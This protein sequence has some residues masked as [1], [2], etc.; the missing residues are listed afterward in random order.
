M[1]GQR[2]ACVES[3]AVR[4][5]RSPSLRVAAWIVGSREAEARAASDDVTVSF[6]FADDPTVV[7]AGAVPESAAAA[8]AS[9]SRLIAD[10]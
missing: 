2:V 4:V 8:A 3:G 9:P 10:G 7:R 6:A 5:G 1:F